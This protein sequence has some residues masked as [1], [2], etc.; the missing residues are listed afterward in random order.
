[1]NA[2]LS[3]VGA[4]RIIVPTVIRRPTSVLSAQGDVGVRSRTQNGQLPTDIG[5][6]RRASFRP[7]CRVLRRQ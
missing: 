2:E 1:M 5:S 4:C 7:R 3:A 6:L